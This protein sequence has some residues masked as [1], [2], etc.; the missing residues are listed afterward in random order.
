MLAQEIE[1]QDSIPTDAPEVAP[2]INQSDDVYDYGTPATYEIGGLTI[3][4]TKYLDEKVLLA[5]SGLRVGDKINLPGEEIPRAIRALWKQGLFSDVQIKA[6]QI[7]NDI[8]FLDVY[9]KERVRLSKYRFSG[10]KKNEE[11]DLRDKIGIYRGR[12]VNENL[13][14]NTINVITDYYKEK[15]FLNAAVIIEQEKDR[16]FTNS[17]IL[18]IDIRRGSKVKINEIVFK[19]NENALP[20]KLKR[21]MKKTKERTQLNKNAPKNIW[22]GLKK[23]K[24]GELLGNLNIGKTFNYVDENIF[25]FKIFSNSKYLEEEFDL[26]KEAIIAYYNGLGYRDARIIQDTVYAVDGKNINIELAVEEGQQYY[27]RDIEWKGNHKYSDATLQNILGIKKGDIYDQSLLQARLFLDQEGGR[28][29]SSLYMDDGYLFFQVN[30]I[31]KA[32][33]D[34]SID[35]VVLVTEGPQATIDNIIIRGNTKTNEHV[36]R[37]MLRSLP[38]SKFSR[39]DIIRS[40]REIANLGFF[41]PEQMNINPIPNPEKG[42]VDIEYQVVEKPSDQLE[43][44]AGWGGSTIVGSVGVSFNNFSLRNIFK[45]DAWAPLPSGDGQRLSFR[46][47][48]TGRAFQSINMSFTEPWLGGKRPN[49]FTVSAYGSRYRQFTNSNS[50]INNTNF[51]DNIA[52]QNNLGDITGTLLIAGAS[53]GLG[54][55][56]TFPDDNFALQTTLT[57]QRFNLNNWSS[58]SGFI[59]NTGN[60]NN[61]SLTTTLSRYSLDQPLYPRTGSNISL[62][63]QLTPPY[64]SW[65]NTNFATASARQKYKW[66]E[67]HKWKF[68]A[69]WYTK[70]VGNLVLKTSAKMGFMGFYNNDIGHSPL[71]RFEVGGDGLSNFDQLFGKDIVSLRGYEIITSNIITVNDEVTTTDSEGV[72]TVTTTPRQVRVADPYFAKYTVELRYPISLNPQS[73]IYGL[74]FVEAGNSWSTFKDFNPF[75]LRRSAGLGLRVFLPMFG[76]LGFDYGVGFDKNVP[77][78]TSFGDYLSKYGRFS[79][80]LGVEPE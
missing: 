38:G 19:G 2:T 39:S 76:L 64:S 57:Y 17:V 11:D 12:I 52:L 61:L 15:G 42:T 78:A 18:G 8:I 32:V 73:T 21:Q 30:P 5:Y 59:I 28:D 55:R 1:V 10:A 46:F 60:I 66:A 49:A 74:A 35:L 62:S 50:I 29:V 31:E 70:I 22:N 53:I 51:E 34:D 75:E 56:L 25:R 7:V 23:A 67:Y 77:D 43:L 65:S 79:V 45:K 58:G 9:L 41:D 71:E 6:A 63:L 4:G 44:S 26:D 69:E 16:L 72:E 47:Q 14:N 48:S 54:R 37:R 13:L 24:F 3:K 33:E 36:I 80:I 27:F 40:Q 68:K 20:R